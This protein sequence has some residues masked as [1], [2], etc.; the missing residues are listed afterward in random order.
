MRCNGPRLP[1]SSVSLVHFCFKRG[2]VTI[3]V[4]HNSSERGMVEIVVILLDVCLHYG[5]EVHISVGLKRVISNMEDG[6]FSFPTLKNLISNILLK[7]SSS[8]VLAS[9][10]VVE[11]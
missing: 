7:S 10:N 8:F 2:M 9:Y 4:I 3:A 1:F 6:F 11:F 5:K